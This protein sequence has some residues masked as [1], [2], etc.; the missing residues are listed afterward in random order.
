MVLDQV[1]TTANWRQGARKQQVIN[2]LLAPVKTMWSQICSILSNFTTPSNLSKQ[3]YHIKNSY[4]WYTTQHWWESKYSTHFYLQFSIQVWT[5]IMSLVYE[6]ETN[7][8][9]FKLV[10]QSMGNFKNIAKTV[11]CRHHRLNC[12]NLSDNSFSKQ[13]SILTSPGK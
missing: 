13:E 2:I 3:H 10:G 7:I 11:A 8:S 9:Y 4:F 6:V 1:L 12:Y 5:R